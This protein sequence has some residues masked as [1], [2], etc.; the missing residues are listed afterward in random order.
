VFAR[1]TDASQARAALAEVA[2]R[3]ED[4]PTRG[5]RSR[6]LI[7][8]VREL[9]DSVRRTLPDPPKFVC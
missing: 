9:E 3:A 5:G 4:L 6:S 8:R 2:A 1:D 7:Q